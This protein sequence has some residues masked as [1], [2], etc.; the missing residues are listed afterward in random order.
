[1]KTRLRNRLSPWHR[2]TIYALTGAMLASGLGWLAVS[3]LLAPANEA[4]PAPHVLAGPL[5]AVHGIAAGVAMIAYALV[6]HTHLRTGW[7]IPAI[8]GAA[9][10]LCAAIVLLFLTGLGFYYIAVEGM[11]P[12]LRWTHVAAGLLLPACLVRHIARGHRA[13]GEPLRRAP[14]NR[15]PDGASP[16]Q[17]DSPS[18]DGASSPGPLA[19]RPTASTSSAFAQETQR[20]HPSPTPNPCARSCGVRAPC[21]AA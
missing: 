10:W 14:E 19:M 6:G 20:P 15:G 17:R 7:Q 16:C 4:G 2:W 5:L 11:I 1:M 3:Y 21:S 13:T 8:R 9:L 12:Y 18:S